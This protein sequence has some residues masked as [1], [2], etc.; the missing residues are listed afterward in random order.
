MTGATATDELSEVDVTAVVEE[1]WA[2]F[3]GA[4]AFMPLIP[5]PPG[6]PAPVDPCWDAAITVA[7]AWQGII[8][9]SLEAGLAHHVT[10]AMLGLEPG[11][12]HTTEDVVDAVGELVNVIGGNIKGLVPGP[13]KLSLPMV[14]RAPIR[15]SSLVE[16]CRLPLS[17]GEHKL[18]LVVGVP[19]GGDT[20]EVGT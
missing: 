15:V 2:T 16:V 6:T 19:E 11:G 12:E 18:S 14:A 17:W 1:V 5:L 20:V 7:G 4:D 3:L 10:E 13:S 8:M 9:I